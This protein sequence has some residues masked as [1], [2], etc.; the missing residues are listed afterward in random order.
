M[1]IALDLFAAVPRRKLTKDP[2][3]ELTPPLHSI[4]RRWGR[5]G[6]QKKQ[7]QTHKR[8]T[9]ARGVCVTAGNG[10]PANRNAG[11]P[12]SGT[13]RHAQKER[14]A[15]AG[16]GEGGAS[17]PGR[18]RSLTSREAVPGRCGQRL[19]R[20]TWLLP[21]RGGAGCRWRTPRL[22]RPCCRRGSARR[23]A[24][25]PGCGSCRPSWASRGR[26]RRAPIAAASVRWGQPA[27]RAR[28]GGGRRGGAAEASPARAAPA[29]GRLPGTALG[30]GAAPGGRWDA[31][32]FPRVRLAR[33]SLVLPL[34][35]PPRGNQPPPHWNHRL[36]PS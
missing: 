5:R 31:A 21:T 24:S 13:W 23:P 3:Q 35:E 25:A 30:G 8:T 36:V 26:P 7:N 9:T 17:G 16:E 10:R 22:T 4:G 29:G 14:E 1:R 34:P 32:V 33:E 28:R 19:G 6:V 11:P 20:V 18:G 12:R 15:R 2:P 27:G